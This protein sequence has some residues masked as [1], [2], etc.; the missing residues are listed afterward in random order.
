MSLRF[1]APFFHEAVIDLPHPAE[2][3]LAL[4]AQENVLGGLDLGPY[5]GWPNALLVCTT[6]TKTDADIQ[7]FVSTLSRALTTLDS[8]KLKGV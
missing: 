2:Q 5:Y 8:N 6:E 4:M 3:V 7:L 1:N